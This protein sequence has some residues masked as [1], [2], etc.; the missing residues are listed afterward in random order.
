MKLKVL[1]KWLLIQSACCN[2]I[3]AGAKAEELDSYPITGVIC[4][5]SMGWDG[6]GWDEMG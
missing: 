2:G 5:E 3:S 1:R 6:M 4:A